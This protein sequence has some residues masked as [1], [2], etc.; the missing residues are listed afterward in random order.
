MT[1]Y[2]SRRRWAI[3]QQEAARAAF[4]AAQPSA[5]NANAARLLQL[6]KLAEMLAGDPNMASA[7]AAV[8]AEI[9]R[10]C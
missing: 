2:Q 10:L 1:G 5:E 9:A 6:R 7:L 4:T 3:K 8:R